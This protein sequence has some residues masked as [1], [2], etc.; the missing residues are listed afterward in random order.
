MKFVFNYTRVTNRTESIVV[1]SLIISSGL[2]HELVVVIRSF[3]SFLD[4]KIS[5]YLEKD[6]VKF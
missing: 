2:N 6:L 4:Y 5:S 3:K 1:G